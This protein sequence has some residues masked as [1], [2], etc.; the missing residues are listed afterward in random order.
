MGENIATYIID[1]RNYIQDPNIS[2]FT[3]ELA[4]LINK[5]NIEQL[6]DVPDFILAEMI[7][8]MIEAMGTSIKSTLDWHGCDSVCHP[9]I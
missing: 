4:D 7:C 5:Y 8:R 1:D 9:H 6:C 2:E 3:K